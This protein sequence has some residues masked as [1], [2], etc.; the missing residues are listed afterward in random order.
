MDDV[1]LEGNTGYFEYAVPLYI[2]LP[3][4]VDHPLH[5]EATD[6]KS[7]FDGQGSFTV[8]WNVNCT[9]GQASA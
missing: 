7:T 1:E 8:A 2:D 6:V 5:I 9:Y 4:E 3:P